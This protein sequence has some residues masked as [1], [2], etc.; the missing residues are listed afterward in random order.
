MDHEL[1]KKSE[2]D[3]PCSWHTF[4]LV[5]HGEV[6]LYHQ[7][8]EG[9]D[10]DNILLM[11]PE[12]RDHEY[13]AG[14][15]PD[16][17]GEK[18]SNL[19]C[20]E[21]ELRHASGELKVNGVHSNRTT[22]EECGDI[23]LRLGK[24]VPHPEL[25]KYVFTVPMPLAIIPG[26]METTPSV[27]IATT[28]GAE[29]PSFLP[30]PPCPTVIPIFLY[31]YYGDNVPC[32]VCAEN[33]EPV[34]HAGGCDENKSIQLYFSSFGPEDK[35]HAQ[36]AFEE[37][38]LLLGVNATIGW[39]DNADFKSQCATPPAGLSWAQVNLPFNLARQ[40]YSDETKRPLLLSAEP[41]RN[42]RLTTLPSSGNCGPGTGG[43]GGR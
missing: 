35:C 6:A 5:L 42:P 36:I 34:F 18:H 38:A 11:V 32:I 40:W 27:Y 14:T 3:D 37:M 41:P 12:V 17:L 28:N 10:H 13:L 19:T 15:W 16:V 1:D 20:H 39:D 25:A 43:G 8:V 21:Y 9:A 4:Y 7:V 30:V 29:P 31:R 26:R 23:F 22:P 24:E 33:G 2:C